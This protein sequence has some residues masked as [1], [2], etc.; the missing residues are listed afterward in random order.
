M[1][2]TLMALFEKKWGRGGENGNK[3]SDDD[4]EVQRRT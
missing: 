4:I 2:L 1:K 3:F